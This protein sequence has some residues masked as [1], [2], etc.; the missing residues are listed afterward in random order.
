MD[1]AGCEGQSVYERAKRTPPVGQDWSPQQ[2]ESLHSQP[3]DPH[4][5]SVIVLWRETISTLE[6]QDLRET[7]EGVGEAG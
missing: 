4:E 6:L 5:R 1:G 3:A 2:L 7:S